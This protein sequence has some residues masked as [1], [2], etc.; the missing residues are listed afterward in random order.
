MPL[1]PPSRGEPRF[2]QQ[3]LGDD[4]LLHLGGAFVDAQQAH[5]AVEPLDLVLGHV[6][7]A[8]VDL[9][10]PVRDAAERLAGEV[11]GG[12]DVGGDP[13]AGVEARRH[14]LDHHPGGVGVGAAVGQHALDQLELADGLAELL[15]LDR[16]ADAFLHQAL[17]HA[18]GQRGQVDAAAVEHLHGGLEAPSGDAADDAGGRRLHVVED[19]VAGHGA[20]LAHLLVE[21]AEADAQ[22]TGRQDEG[23]DAGRALHVRLAPWPSP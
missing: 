2:A 5:V 3:R 12:G 22:G 23:A 20:L 7:G 17:A 9:H 16:V 6:A 11:F 13:L 8:A 19:D 10:R 21:L 14:V 15:A 18:A 4:G 1:R